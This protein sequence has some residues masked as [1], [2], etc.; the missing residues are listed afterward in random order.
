MKFV[1]YILPALLVCVL[2]NFAI[3]QLLI[4]SEQPAEVDHALYGWSSVVKGKWALVGAPQKD[5]E[6]IQAAGSVIFYSKTG[7]NWNIQQEISL[8]ELG[9]FSNFGISLDLGY[10]DALI[11]ATGDH[12]NGIFSGAVYAYEFSDTAWVQVQ[13]LKP[14]DPKAGSRFGQALDI[15]ASSVVI[16]AYQADGNVSKSGAAYV[17][18][19]I[20]GSWNQTAKLIPED[21][22]SHDYFGY[23]VSMVTESIVA[24]GAYNADGTNERTGVVYI[25]EKNNEDNWEQTAKLFDPIGA[26]SDL[27][28]FSITSS[29]VFVVKS[30]NSNYFS[31]FLYIGAPG[32]L[33]ENGKTGSVYLYRKSDNGS[34]TLSSELVEED[35]KH[36]DHFGIS[37]AA[38]DYGGFYVG[39]S[40]SSQ[41]SYEKTGTVYQYYIWPFFDGISNPDPETNII[42]IE[43]S[44]EFDN[45]G[46]QVAADEFTL[47]VSSPHADGESTSNSGKV[48]FFNY[49]FVSNEEPPVKEHIEYRLDQNY[50]NPFNPA[51]TINYAV[52]E[53]GMVTLTVYNL[54]GQVVQI[55]VNEQKPTG[56]YQVT[57]NANN[58]ASG[59]YFYRL[60]VNDFVD[61]KRMTLIK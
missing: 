56:N 45:F 35:S 10:S 14:S 30:N 48:Y 27:F 5:V 47:L 21:G 23:S 22:T 19:K 15:H 43:E 55:L 11:G 20:D 59:A 7:T 25:F 29:L 50:P 37:I 52:K 46:Y 4:P 53:T 26:S 58:L 9:D 12:E 1:K 33:N 39:S 51:T 41:N 18:E 24:V 32:T 13:K 61:Y 44:G 28:G 3:A 42:S 60:E 36:N 6:N 16:G 34:W 31:G 49:N 54:L 8:P 17:F 40:R 57:F 2:T 38:T